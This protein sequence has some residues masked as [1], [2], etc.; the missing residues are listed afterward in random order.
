V[1]LNFLH[2]YHACNLHSCAC[3]QASEFG[4]H[5][6]AIITVEDVDEDDDSGDTTSHVQM[7]RLSSTA[8]LSP[9][10]VTAMMM[11]MTMTMTS[12]TKMHRMTV[13]RYRPI[14]LTVQFDCLC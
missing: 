5:Q 10:T 7:K 9:S 4:E 6:A 12:A 2:F 13:V 14:G 8:S 11:T 1:Y 3:V